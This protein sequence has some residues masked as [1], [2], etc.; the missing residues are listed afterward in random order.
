M[1][2]NLSSSKFKQNQ[3]THS[4]LTTNDNTHILPNIRKVKLEILDETYYLLFLENDFVFVNTTD[5]DLLFLRY[6]IS[7]NSNENEHLER[8]PSTTLFDR[9]RSIQELIW[10]KHHDKIDSDVTVVNKNGIRQDCRLTN[11]ERIFIK[12]VHSNEHFTFS[13]ILI[14]MKIF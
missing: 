12:T 5:L 3:S 7:S 9:E 6:K 4:L 10:M 8:L 2:P 13:I 14:L 11:L 1:A